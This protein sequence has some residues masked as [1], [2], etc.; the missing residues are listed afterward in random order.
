MVGAL[1]ELIPGPVDS[2]YS[3]P[4]QPDEREV[5]DAALRS[6]AEIIGETA[7]LTDE[8]ERV[9]HDNADLMRQIDALHA[10]PTYKAKERLVEIA[11]TNYAA[12]MGLGAYRRLRER[13]SR[14]T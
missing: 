12:R 8:L 3:D 1:D 14:S 13:N 4:D 11:Q 5:S 2:S 7:R 6:L 9:H 10:T